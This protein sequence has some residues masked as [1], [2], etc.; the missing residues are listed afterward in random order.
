LFELRSVNYQDIL[1][2]PD[3]TI[4]KGR[5]TFICGESGSGKSTLLKLL[6][7][8]LSPSGGE[9]F[10]LNKTLEDYDPILLRRE[11]LLVGQSVYLFDK[12]IK[13]NFN[14]YYAYRDMDIINEE[15]I[16]KYLGICSV[17]LPLEG[18]CHMLSGG[19]RQRVFIAINLS[20]RPKVLMM[21][22]PTSAL[23][24]KNANILMENIKAHC[25]ANDMTLIVVSHDK[26]IAE[27]YADSII[28]LSNS[29]NG[30]HFEKGVSQK[31]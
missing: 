4:P 22:E 18:M 2:F 30:S 5:A 26:A 14:E 10:Y 16:K 23:D 29:P 24:D 28:T 1:T 31:S 6:N 17:N 7:G 8:V 12:S 21:D 19:E 3:M 27:K 15:E 13:D 11:I 25:Q 9:I 20:Y